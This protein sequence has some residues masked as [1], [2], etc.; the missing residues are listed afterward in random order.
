MLPR[1]RVASKARRPEA[2]QAG[3]RQST[4]GHTHPGTMVVCTEGPAVNLGTLRNLV[5]I[6][7]YRSN[8]VGLQS[9]TNRILNRAL[10][11]AINEP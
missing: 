5:Y 8:L 3:N 6:D 10:N 1:R 4:S 7:I 9:R 2:H 11:R